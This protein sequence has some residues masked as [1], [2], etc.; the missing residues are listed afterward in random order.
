MVPGA[1]GRGEAQRWQKRSWDGLATPQAG[2]GHRLGVP[3]A[4]RAA[5]SPG[6]KYPHSMQVPAPGN[7]RALQPGHTAGPGGGAETPTRPGADRSGLDVVPAAMIPLGVFG[8]TFAVAT[9]AGAGVGAARTPKI[10][11]QSGQRTGL[12]TASSGT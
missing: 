10:F 12:P 2:L 9:P 5:P 1:I 3:S 7:S 11:L 8:P 4:S 6:S